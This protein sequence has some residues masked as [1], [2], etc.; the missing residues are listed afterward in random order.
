M[1]SHSFA[2]DPRVLLGEVAEGPRP[3]LPRHI[4]LFLLV[5]VMIPIAALI[6]APVR[7]WTR[8]RH[9][10]GDAPQQD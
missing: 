1:S 5:A 7:L 9:L 3:I 8:V 10:V 2:D 6:D 4:G